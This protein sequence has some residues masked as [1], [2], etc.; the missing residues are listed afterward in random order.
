MSIYKTCSVNLAGFANRLAFSRSSSLL[1]S[2]PLTFPS[3]IPSL[4]H[5]LIHNLYTALS[6]TKDRV[7]CPGFVYVLFS[8]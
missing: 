5:K 2:Y 8:T 3:S 6:T 7:V 1:E 4:F